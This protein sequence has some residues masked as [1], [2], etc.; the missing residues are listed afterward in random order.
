M[1][2]GRP[3]LLCPGAGTHFPAMGRR[4]YDRYPSARRLLGDLTQVVGPD[5]VDG[6]LSDLPAHTRTIGQS[7][8]A[9]VAI[10]LLAEAA[11][12]EELGRRPGYAVTG[13]YSLGLFTALAV[14]GALAV[15]DTIS[16]VVARARLMQRAADQRAGT[17]V[18][19]TGPAIGTVRE[20]VDACPAELGRVVIA[21][22]NS[23]SAVML[24][25][26]QA[27]VARV[28]GRLAGA[29][30]EVKA[31][32]TGVASHSPLMR[33]AQ[34]ELNACLDQ[35][36]IVEP[37]LPVLLNSDGGATTDPARIRDEL[38]I[39]LVTPVRWDLC[40]RTLAEVR[41]DL[42]V[43]TGP[44]GMMARLTEG[45]APAVLLNAAA[46]LADAVACLRTSEE[47]NTPSGRSL[48]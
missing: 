11:L 30:T 47:S 40:A 24:S 26:D 15:A 2:A 20:E 10:G 25:G 32:R 41:P 35:V 5:L 18:L 27:A 31:A 12:V 23:P 6:C 16:L 43:D 8:P 36:S 33:G 42:I 44:G 22:V 14:A 4:L 34:D 9:T 46:P 7:Y 29:G 48:P 21:C 39:H 37:E 13:G 38:R 28:A 3:A 45:I 19:V 1:T 17:M